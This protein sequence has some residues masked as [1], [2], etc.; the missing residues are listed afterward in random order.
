MFGSI[1]NSQVER[2]SSPLPAR[3]VQIR[4]ASADLSQLHLQLPTRFTSIPYKQQKNKFHSLNIA[5]K[6]IIIA[7]VH[8]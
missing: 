3:H 5:I 8:A 1:F 2:E 4:L 7:D 6:Q